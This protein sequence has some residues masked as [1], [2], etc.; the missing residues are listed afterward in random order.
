MIEKFLQLLVVHAN[1]SQ[2]CF[3]GTAPVLAPNVQA[4]ENPRDDTLYWESN[5]GPN[6]LQLLPQ[7]N[8]F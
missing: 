1:L 5:L 2:F 4:N 7:N 6:K 3:L 8:D